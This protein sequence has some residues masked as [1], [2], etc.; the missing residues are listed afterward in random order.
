M[1]T[2]AIIQ[3]PIHILLCI[4]DLS[5]TYNKHFGA[6]MASVIINTKYPVVFHLIYDENIITPKSQEIA[7]LNR[8]N[9]ISLCREHKTSIYFHHFSLPTQLQK[10]FGL[11]N[12]SPAALLRLF[13]ADILPDLDRIIYLDGDI[14]VNMDLTQLWTEC[15]ISAYPLGACLEG[16][17]FN[18]GF[19]YM[20]L[21]MIREK[22]TLSKIAIDSL[23]NTNLREPDQL[24]L[25]NVFW[26]SFL[27]LEPKYN[28]HVSK[29]NAD[30]LVSEQGVMHF[31]VYKPWIN[32]QRKEIELLYWKYLSL[33]PWGD[34]GDKLIMDSWDVLDTTL[35]SWFKLPK[36]ALKYEIKKIQ[37]IILRH[38][39][40]KNQKYPGDK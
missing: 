28:Y 2:S 14:I 23:S 1:R 12:W 19:L 29:E 33:S 15:D 4:Y 17:H 31:V 20:N 16:S 35:E 10:K 22:Y 25:N 8:D 34:T 18:S 13:A 7:N 6:T 36:V 26:D 11:W 30:L 21:K 39:K 32:S 27:P 3:E 40:F 9:Y 5:D 24:I 38:T 37:H